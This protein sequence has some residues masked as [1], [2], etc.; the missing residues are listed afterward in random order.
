MNEPD[1]RNANQA[2]RSALRALPVT[3]VFGLGACSSL[4]PAAVTAPAPTPQRSA[5]V[6]VLLVPWSG[7]DGGLPPFDRVTPASLAAAYE[8]AVAD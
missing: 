2:I 5:D 6:E 4:P 3:I 7:P 8:V 1:R